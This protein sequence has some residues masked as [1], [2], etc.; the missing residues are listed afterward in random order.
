MMNRIRYFEAVVR[1]GSFSG[2][3]EECYISQ[4]AVSQQIRAL[5]RDLGVTLLNRGN[6]RRVSLTPAGE[7]FYRRSIP[8]MEEFER[9]RE[10]TRRIAAGGSNAL[11]VG[12]PRGYGG[13]EFRLA[14]ADFAAKYPDIPVN[15]TGGSHEELYERLRSGRVDLILS[16][17]RR[18]FSDEYV[19]SVLSVIE[20]H[21]EIS[22]GSPVAGSGF[23]DVTDLRRTP[24][25]LVASAEQRDNERAY[26]REIYGIEGEFLFAENLDEARLMAVGG[27][28]YL[29]VEGGTPPPQFACTLVCLPLRRNGKPVRR[30]YCAFRKA[31]NGGYYTAEFEKILAARFAGK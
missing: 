16:D 14:V 26:Y 20:C 25:I 22:A 23:A 10:E 19:N 17:Q 27:R 31:D 28:G 2:A 3:A 9:L 7:Y 30:S 12:F 18:A 1:L 13:E 8:L 21:I 4:S 24:C 6:S 11:R 29:P 5:E 15:V